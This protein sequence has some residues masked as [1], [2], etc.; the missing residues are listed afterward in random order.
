MK[1]NERKELVTHIYTADPSA[2]VFNG[3]IYI[4]PSHDEDNDLPPDDDG[5]QYGQNLNGNFYRIGDHHRSRPFFRCSTMRMQRSV[6]QMPSK[7]AIK[8]MTT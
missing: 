5:E 2:H 7:K 1:K 3:K 4:Y 6:R 8:P